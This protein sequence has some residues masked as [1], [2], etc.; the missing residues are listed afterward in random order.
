MPA[1][2]FQREYNC[3]G[4]ALSEHEATLQFSTAPHIPSDHSTDKKICKRRS[5]RKKQPGSS[6]RQRT[7]LRAERECFT[8]HVSSKAG[9]RLQ[10]SGRYSSI[11]LASYCGLLI[12]FFEV[13]ARAVEHSSE[14]VLRANM[15]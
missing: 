12:L 9:C 2:L 6:R 4:V 1:R 3:P 5:R 7:N 15:F 8:N 10:L 13:L 14:I 11:H